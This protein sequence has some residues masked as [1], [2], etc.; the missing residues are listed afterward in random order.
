MLNRNREDVA[1]LHDACPDQVHQRVA[2]DVA[3]ALQQPGIAGLHALVVLG[4]GAVER[5]DGRLGVQAGNGFAQRGQQHPLDL[6]ERV[7]P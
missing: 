7:L 5:V 4:E 2:L 3:D 1:G 6:A